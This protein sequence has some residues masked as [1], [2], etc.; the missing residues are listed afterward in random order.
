MP[1]APP[2][3]LAA[4]LRTRNDEQLAALL[5]A[6][7]RRR[8]AGA[9][10]R[11][12]PGQPAGRAGVGGPRPRRARRRRRCRCSTWCCSPT[13]DGVPRAEL[14]AALPDVAG[15]VLE[16]ALDRADRPG[17]AVG[18]RRPARARPGA[19]RGAAPRRA[20]PPGRRP[21]GAAARRPAGRC[22][23]T[24]PRTSAT[25]LDRLAGD[26]PV[27][28]LPD[29]PAGA[30][31]PARRLLQRGLL[32]RIDALNVELPRE[33][34]L[35]LRG[36]RPYGP[37]RLRPEPAAHHPRPADGRPAG[38]RR[39]AGVGR[40]GRRAAHRSS[41]RSRPGCCAAAGVGVRDQKRLARDLHVPRARRRVAAGAGATPPACST[42]AGRTAT[43]GCPPATYDIW[44]EQ[45]LADRWAVLAA[46]WLAGV[47][48]TVPRRAAGRGG[49]GGQRALPRPGPAHRARRSAA[50][51]WRRSP[52]YPAGSGLAP[53]DLSPCCAGAPRGGPTGWRRSRGCSPRP[54]GSGSS[55]AG[56]CPPVGAGC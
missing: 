56:C 17:T 18:R 27:G 24:W 3:T 15:E 8:P 39:G 47:R 16:R 35:L 19:A 20:G 7:S 46:G 36:D 37:P 48:L 11:R 29:S 6:A 22:S 4:W 41:R 23:P 42:S 55:S 26:R 25:V 21:A 2:P 50:R 54:P 40:P 1:A 10:G 53:D 44:R 13:T 33:I 52:S 49:Q 14:R 31:P 28:H 45:D 51:R 32:A 38:G 9:L 5:A 30:R 43:S 34:G 12:R